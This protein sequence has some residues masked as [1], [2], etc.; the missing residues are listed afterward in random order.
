MFPFHIWTLAILVGGA[1][2]SN[3]CKCAIEKPPENTRC[4]YMYIGVIGPQSGHS[5]TL[6][7][8]C[9]SAAVALPYEAASSMDSANHAVPS[10][11][12]PS[13]HVPSSLAVVARPPR[14]Q[15]PTWSLV[16]SEAI[17]Q[18]VIHSRRSTCHSLP[19]R[20]MPDQRSW[21][22]RLQ[23]GFP[24]HLTPKKSMPWSGCST[25]RGCKQH[26]V[27]KVKRSARTPASHR[28]LPLAC[29]L[30]PG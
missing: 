11:N 29:N 20:K 25:K 30:S 2:V 6:K 16:L 23:L 9:S 22:L 8:L 4:M 12:A 19:S 13:N 26:C 18:M 27:S 28:N 15:D 7:L 14:V 24:T 1:R 3:Q 10:S 5:R 21:S 17:Q